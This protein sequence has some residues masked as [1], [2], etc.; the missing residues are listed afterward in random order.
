MIFPLSTTMKDGPSTTTWRSAVAQVSA[1]LSADIVAVRRHLHA[2]PE[3]SMQEF[4]TTAYLVERVESLGVAVDLTDQRIGLIGDWQSQ[5]TEASLRRIG[6]RGDIDALPIATTCSEQYASRSEGVMH[7][8]GHDAHASMVWGAL[9]I[10][11]ELDRQSALPWPVAVRAIF[12]PAEETSEGGPLMIAA[13]ALQGLSGVLALHVDPTLPVG[14]VAGRAGPFT[15]ACDCFDVE[16]IGRAGHS[17]RPHLCID[18]LAAAASWIGEMYARVP[19]IHDC[20]DPAVVSVGTIQGGAAANIVAGQTQLSGTIRTFSESARAAIMQEMRN[21]AE[22]TE[23]TFG[24]QVEVTFSA[25][26]PSV[27]NDP[28]L[29]RTMFETAQSL[30]SVEQVETIELPSMGAEDFAFFAQHKPVCMMRLGIAGPLRGAHALHT[31]AFDIDERALCIGAS[32]LAATAI[33]LCKRT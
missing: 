25:Y 15:A 21:V 12:Q 16:F 28:E 29:H 6:L 10:L 5:Q 9:A 3:L 33:E 31:A 32:L 17:A 26:T 27:H 2:N 19:R 14:K 1:R 18:A 30:S 8:C 11:R 7:A 4:A 20:R 23:K 24:C 13:G 22:A